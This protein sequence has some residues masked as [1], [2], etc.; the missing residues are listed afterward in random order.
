MGHQKA[1]LQWKCLLGWFLR[2]CRFCCRRRLS[3]S[4]IDRTT[5]V[6][7]DKLLCCSIT[8]WRTFSWQIFWWSHGVGSE[9]SR[10]FD[11]NTKKQ[12]YFVAHPKLLQEQTFLSRKNAQSR[13]W[14]TWHH[15][16]KATSTKT[17]AK[18]AAQDSSLLRAPRSHCQSRDLH[19]KIIRA[20]SLEHVRWR[21]Q[22]EDR[23]KCCNDDMDALFRFHSAGGCTTARILR[24][25]IAVAV[26][27][28]EKASQLESWRNFIQARLMSRVLWFPRTQNVYPEPKSPP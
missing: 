6:H 13:Q 8:E 18:W 10:I 24:N 1:K 26:A 2:R 5:E 7:V 22:S 25:A 11:G 12:S 3:F 9:M 17:R 27:Q 21:I 4:L 16:N 19:W 15:P 20:F 28:T 14:R 23:W